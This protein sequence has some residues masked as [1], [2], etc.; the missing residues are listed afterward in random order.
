M[1]LNYFQMKQIFSLLLHLLNL[2]KF[3]QIVAQLQSTMFLNQRC[4]TDAL[5]SLPDAIASP[6]PGSSPS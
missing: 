1:L 5:E 4:A 2:A 6:T 3:K